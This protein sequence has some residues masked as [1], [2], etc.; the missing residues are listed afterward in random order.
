MHCPAGH[1]A[2]AHGATL[3]AELVTAGP[4]TWVSWPVVNTMGLGFR[5]RPAADRSR[6]CVDGGVSRCGQSARTAL[7]YAV[8]DVDVHRGSDDGVEAA[9]SAEALAAARPNPLLLGGLHVRAAHIR[10]RRGQAGVQIGVH[11]LAARA[12]FGVPSAELDAVQL[13][14]AAVLGRMEFDCATA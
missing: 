8:L 6:C 3:F 1:R 2:T 14:A 11:P 7:G 13:D 10:Q 5:C 9:E 4:L 12:L